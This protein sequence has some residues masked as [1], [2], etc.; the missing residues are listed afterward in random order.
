MNTKILFS[1][2]LKKIFSQKAYWLAL[3]IMLLILISNEAIPIFTGNYQSKLDRE[4]GL[5]GTVVNEQ[6]IREIQVADEP[7]KY[8]PIY[9]LLKSTIRG[10]DISALTEEQL[11]SKRY[12]SVYTLMQEENLTEQELAYWTKKDAE[13]V[14]PFV[15]EYD[16]A[17]EAFLDVVYV[18]SLM[19]LILCGVGLSGLYAGE[20]ANGTDQIIFGT[21]F[22]KNRLFTVKLVVGMLCGIVSSLLLVVGHLAVCFL[23]YGTEG[24]QTMLQL[25]IPL[26]MMKIS[27][28]QAVLLILALVLISGLFL[29]I[30]AMFLSQLTMNQSETMALMIFLMFLSMFNPPMEIRFIK[31]AFDMLPGAFVGS[32]LFTTYSTIN[33]L[34]WRL[35][36]FQYTPIIWTI[37]GIVLVFLTW[38]RYERYEVKAR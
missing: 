18:M 3:A 4:K 28:G 34:G 23:M 13:N 37:V 17:Y 8:D 15:Y 25:H 6:I 21:R 30:I 14:T 31:M 24:A 27:V 33:I 26:C 35:N 2:E 5:S 12:D 32:W 10:N 22:G 36:V 9:L 20:K 7:H 11:Y 1:Y 19:V 29:S 38:R 16:G